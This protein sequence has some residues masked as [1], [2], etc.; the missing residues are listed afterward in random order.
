[1]ARRLDAHLCIV[2]GRAHGVR[3][4][5]GDLGKTLLADGEEGILL[6]LS[7]LGLELEKDCGS[8]GR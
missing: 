6:L 1:M 5:V 4:A 8:E 2:D 7:E 3:G